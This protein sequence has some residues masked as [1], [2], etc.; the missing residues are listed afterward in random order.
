M[1]GPNIVK[2]STANAWKRLL[3][4][5]IDLALLFML[6]SIVCDFAKYLG[7]G[8]NLLERL[9]VPVIALY[10]F[11]FETVCQRT[12]GKL[13]T[14]TLVTQLDGSKPTASQILKRTA[15]RFSI[16][17]CIT[18]FR[19]EAFMW[20]DAKSFTM[21]VNVTDRRRLLKCITRITTWVFGSICL[22][23]GFCCYSADVITLAGLILV[24]IYGSLWFALLGARAWAWWILLISKIAIIPVAVI[25]AILSHDMICAVSI[26]LLTFII[27]GFPLFILC[28]DKPSRWKTVSV[29]AYDMRYRDLTHEV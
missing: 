4:I 16:V 27:S 11:I 23:A 12:L 6:L 3:N 15:I 14:S 2:H 25:V 18:A 10:Y 29:D 20:H 28:K 13:A 17:D 21:L 8:N 26:L 9:F 1:N 7:V 19:K 22:F 24:I 5:C